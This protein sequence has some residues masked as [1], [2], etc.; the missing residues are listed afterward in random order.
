MAMFAP[1]FLAALFV[2]V[3]APQDP[4]PLQEAERQVDAAIE[5]HRQADAIAILRKALK[6]SPAWRQ[7][8]W[9]LGSLLY[10]LEN[11]VAARPVLE[12]LTQLDPKSGAPWVVLGLCEFEM[13]DYGLALQHLQ[14]G[15]ALGVPE[16]LDL[17]PVVRYHEAL[18]LILMNRFDPAQVLLDQLAHRSEN[19]DEVVLAEGLAALRIPALPESLQ[20]TADDDR[21]AIIR[22]VGT[23]QRAIALGTPREGVE[24][25]KELLS[26]NPAIPNLHLSY[27]ALLLQIRET[28][29]AEAELRAELKLN[30]RSVEVRLRLCALLGDDSPSDMAHL[31]EEAV[32]LDPKSFKAHF[33]L[34][35]L[36]F[37]TEKLADSARELEIS[38]DLDP[39]SSMV[40]FAL[41][42]TY[43]A[44]GREADA[45]R[46][47]EVFER[48]RA[49]EDQFRKTGRLP[50][51][52]FEPGE[53][54]Q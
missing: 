16:Q 48:M 36:L 19:A 25:Y 29:A 34:G 27:A 30:P 10:N 7:G 11:Y 3:P 17:L 14:R 39:S 6:G 51:S 13:K 31:A 8:W 33:F 50:A 54:K 45:K 18:L 21:L 38:R 41:V 49:A 24:V 40:R 43:M 26:K 44:L 28:Q 23:A 46:E 22:R 47:T 32:K 9:R 37:K 12:R 15:D 35:K 20:N 42:R 53:R 1:F 52:F 5:E 2:A 4:K